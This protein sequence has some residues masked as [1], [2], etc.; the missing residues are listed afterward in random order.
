MRSCSESHKLVTE[1][2]SWC[3]HWNICYA[4]HDTHTRSSH[5]LSL[6]Y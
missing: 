1:H 4:G 6:S 5:T 2:D 3:H